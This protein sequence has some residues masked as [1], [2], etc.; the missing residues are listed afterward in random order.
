METNEPHTPENDPNQQQPEELDE[1]QTKVR[2]YPD[3]QWNLIQR[4]VGAALGL[5][6]GFLLTYFGAYES[7]GMFGTIGAVLVALFVPNLIEKRVKRSVRKGRIALMIALGAWL[8]VF[9][10]VMLIKGV[11]IIANPA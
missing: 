7:T 6:C 11:P 9:V 5:A 3:Q 8:V 1:L 10:A 2:N 4:V